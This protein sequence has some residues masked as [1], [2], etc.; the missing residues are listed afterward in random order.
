MMNAVGRL[1][2]NAAMALAVVVFLRPT[3]DQLI[4]WLAASMLVVFSWAGFRYCPL[5]DNGEVI[6]G[7]CAAAVTATHVSLMAAVFVVPV[8]LKATRSCLVRCTVE[9]SGGRAGRRS[10][11]TV[12]ALSTKPG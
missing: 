4:L 3:R 9:D 8:A 10:L 12:A 11:V 6:S 1:L 7:P 5:P 2:F